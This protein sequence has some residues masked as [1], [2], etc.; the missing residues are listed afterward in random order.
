[1]S[2]ADDHMLEIERLDREKPGWDHNGRVAGA[3]VGLKNKIPR[4][5]LVHVYGEEIVREAETTTMFDAK[6]ES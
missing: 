6:G 3:H 2:E 5:L 1:M 4:D